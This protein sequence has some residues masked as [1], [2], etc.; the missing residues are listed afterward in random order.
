MEIDAFSEDQC[1]FLTPLPE[2]TGHFKIAVLVDLPIAHTLNIAGTVEVMEMKSGGVL[3][4]ERV[5]QT[6][7]T[8][9]GG[10]GVR[11]SLQIQ[12]SWVNE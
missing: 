4:P 12:I 5:L 10:T 7:C 11:P 3:L 1:L 8:V 9:G 6:G 2:L